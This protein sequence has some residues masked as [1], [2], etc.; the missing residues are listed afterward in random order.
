MGFWFRS[1]YTHA[2][3]MI[4]LPLLSPLA[5]GSGTLE[6]IP[7]CPDAF[8]LLNGPS[9]LSPNASFEEIRGA[10]RDLLRKRTTL[11]APSIDARRFINEDD[12]QRA[13]GLTKPWTYYGRDSMKDWL[14]ALRFVQQ[15]AAGL[16][17][18]LDLLQKLHRI[19]A[20]RLPFHGFEG[21]RIR[22]LFDE[23]K[24]TREEFKRRLDRAYQKNEE[25]SGVSHESL[26]GVMRTE[27]ID[28][29]WHSGSSLSPE[30]G[31][32]FTDS[33][34]AAIRSNPYMRVDEANMKQIAPGKWE[35]RA[36]YQ[37][38]D[39]VK[40]SVEKVLNRTVADLASAMSDETSLTIIIQMEKDLMSIHPFLDGNGRTIRLLGDLLRQ[41]EGLPP[42]LY[43]NE[44]D[45]TMTSTEAL[46][47]HR[48]AMI[49]YLNE[50]SKRL[51]NKN[52]NESVPA[53]RGRL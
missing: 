38:V 8:R 42:P 25:V 19:S 7:L 31:R 43:P 20:R 2:F 37:D 13:A 28:Q 9:G 45:L 29:I 26:R 16:P 41:R 1:S 27:Q 48:R 3:W 30:I 18:S 49:D 5:K 4:L 32:Y 6:P 10:Y 50:W 14:D 47:F 44:S 36:Y 21:R 40:D 52:I 23:G 22:K 46:A 35:G 33:E 12:W 11:A 24:I 34:L 15:N 53:T 39:L 17:V 51:R